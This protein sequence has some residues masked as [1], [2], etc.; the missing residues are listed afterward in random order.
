MVTYDSLVQ[1]RQLISWLFC[2]V[3]LP[4]VWPFFAAQWVCLQF[5]IVVF[6]DHTHLLLLSYDM[7][8]FQVQAKLRGF[9]NNIPHR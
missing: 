1:L 5:V 7:H 2:F 4:S 9:S 6:S 8:I 3:C